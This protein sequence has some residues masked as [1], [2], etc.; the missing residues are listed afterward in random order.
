MRRRLVGS[1]LVSATAGVGGGSCVGVAGRSAGVQRP[2]RCARS[3]CRARSLDRS[4][5]KP[6]AARVIAPR[7]R[8]PGRAPLD[9]SQSRPTGGGDAR[10]QRPFAVACPTADSSRVGSP[11]HNDEALRRSAPGRQ[12]CMCR[13]RARGRS[14]S[15]PKTPSEIAHDALPPNAGWAA[16]SRPACLPR[17]A[18][19]ERDGSTDRDRLRGLGRPR[20]RTGQDQLSLIAARRARG[21]TPVAPPAWGCP[22]TPGWGRLICAFRPVLLNSVMPEPGRQIGARR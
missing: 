21:S 9:P 18:S 1:R 8:S 13:F 20:T 17:A 2:G 16:R 15:R 7:F 3:P 11:R 4:R 22:R 5:R 19:R 14:S 10:G 6:W 12:R